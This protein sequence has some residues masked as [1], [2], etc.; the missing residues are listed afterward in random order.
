MS[1]ASDFVKKYEKIFIVLLLAF[2][3]VTFG[4]AGWGSFF[5]KAPP[6]SEV[7]GRKVPVSEQ[8]ATGEKL[9][10]IARL[11][12]AAS[13]GALCNENGALKRNARIRANQDPLT[14]LCLLEIARDEGIV[15][16]DEE[17]TEQMTEFA[18]G[19]VT[20][21]NFW[22]KNPD[23]DFF[24]NP[25]ARTEKQ[26]Q[27]D[28]ER[29]AVE[30]MGSSDLLERLREALNNRQFI[31]RPLTVQDFEILLRE[32][33][34]YFKL[35]QSVQSSVVVT[36]E[37]VYDSFKQQNK[38]RGFDVLRVRVSQFNEEAKAKITD[39][40]KREAYEQN[41]EE[42]RVPNMVK[43]EALKVMRDRLDSPTPEE[44][45]AR[46]DEDKATRYIAKKGD[47][48]TPDEYRPL[49]DVEKAVERSIYQD[50]EEGWLQKALTKARELRDQGDEYS[51]LD[52]VPEERRGFF[53][54]IQSEPYGVTAYDDVND[55][56]KNVQALRQVL[57]RWDS[58]EEGDLCSFPAPFASG[59]FIYR[60]VEKIPG[61]ARDY[62]DV[63][64]EKLVEKATEIKARELARETLAAYQ[65]GIESGEPYD[66]GGTTVDYT[67]ENVAKYND[68]SYDSAD[69]ISL[70]NSFQFQLGGRPYSSGRQLVQAG[71]QLENPGDI[72]DPIITTGTLAD[73][74]LVKFREEVDP[75]PSLFE[76]MKITIRNQL[77]RQR[78][79]E[80]I[81]AFLDQVQQ[82]IRV[83]TS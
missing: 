38:L 56:I 32:Q 8:Q 48:E 23:I 67:L 49:E 61:K 28:A 25:G 2:L 31:Y 15:C 20:Q 46:Y 41:K 9:L 39:E 24:S 79:N 4:F 12:N 76:S 77:E 65:A 19:L 60:V 64:E 10:A 42:F 81:Q 72:S 27:L 74:V 63:P 35:I 16:T 51:L 1:A 75:D 73:A 6:P 50:L 62:E 80:I 30:A 29:E 18:R 45:Q 7:A 57:S 82:K 21:Y 40:D 69:P 14:Y 53:E 5:D 55:Q 33:V 34:V 11:S 43:V 26:G 47:G 83:P 70:R 36:E 78:S 3:S 68:F 22:Q 44:L 52:T 17:L 58:L 59:G 13:Y 66:L 54:I 71:F 37:E